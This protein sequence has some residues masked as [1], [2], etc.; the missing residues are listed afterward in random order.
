MESYS[1]FGQ[2]LVVRKLIKK[3]RRGFFVDLGCGNFKN[4]NN[5]YALEMESDWTGICIDGNKQHIDSVVRGR[6][7]LAVHESIS[8]VSGEEVAFLSCHVVGGIIGRLKDSPGANK[9]Q[10]KKISKSRRQAFEDDQIEIMVTKTL[11][12][13]LDEYKAPDI[14][15]YLSIDIR[16]TEID[17]LKTLKTSKR[18]YA[19]ISV[20]ISGPDIDYMDVMLPM[21]YKYIRC[22]RDFIFYREDLLTRYR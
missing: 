11:E 17:I 5:T 21:G 3:Y 18:S 16:G 10:M 9:E 12:Q 4:L 1:Q 6:N 7:A 8:D 20:D 2:D 13:V 15:D 19:I 22:A 14:I